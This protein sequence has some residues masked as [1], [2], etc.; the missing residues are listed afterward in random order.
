LTVRRRAVDRGLVTFW[1]PA[2][3]MSAAELVDQLADPHRYAGAYRQ[4][5]A[6]GAAAAG[7][8]RDG[9]AHESPRVRML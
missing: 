7:P 3:G 9:L 1:E 2:A 5:I 4:L 8:A 6:L